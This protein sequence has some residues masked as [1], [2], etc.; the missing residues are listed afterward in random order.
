MGKVII[1]NEVEP[2][3]LS[4]VDTKIVGCSL[5]HPFLEEHGLSHSERAAVG[6]ATRRLIRIDTPCGEVGRWDV[7]TGKG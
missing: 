1:A 7:V 5:H 2:S 3:K 6:N 4:L